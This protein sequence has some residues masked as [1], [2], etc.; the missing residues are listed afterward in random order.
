[1]AK[2]EVVLEAV[3]R[4][5]AALVVLVET[6]GKFVDAGEAEDQ[7]C[8][9]LTSEPHL[10]GL[11]FA[12]VLRVDCH[13]LAIFVQLGFAHAHVRV[14]RGHDAVNGVAQRDEHV[15]RGSKHPP[16]HR[17]GVHLIVRGLEWVPRV[18]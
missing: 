18:Q 17:V 2:P 15:I 1:M 12:L 11:A 5:T 16:S 13:P 3:A 4:E 6:L 10:V 8:V 7:P 14:V 9:G